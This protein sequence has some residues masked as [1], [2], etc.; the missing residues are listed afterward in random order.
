MLISDTA[1]MLI[2]AIQD[3]QSVEITAKGTWRHKSL[4]LRIVNLFRRIILGYD[5]ALENA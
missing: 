2:R 5:E 1:P 3:E 4:L